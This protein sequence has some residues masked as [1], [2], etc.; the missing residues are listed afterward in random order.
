MKK[1]ALRLVRTSVG[2]VL[3]PGG[4]L[5]GLVLVWMSPWLLLALGILLVSDTLAGS[6]RSIYQ[7]AGALLRIAA[8]LGALIVSLDLTI[9]GTA[10]RLASERLMWPLGRA[11]YYLVRVVARG[12][13][14]ACGAG[15]S[16]VGMWWITSFLA[17]TV[18]IPDEGLLPASLHIRLFSAPL[19]AFC[20]V[21]AL[22]A[23]G[24]VSS[25]RYGHLVY[26]LGM[27]MTVAMLD[28]RVGGPGWVVSELA[29]ALARWL[30]GPIVRGPD[31]VTVAVAGQSPV[32]AVALVAEW[33]WGVGLALLAGV[34][35][36]DRADIT[37]RG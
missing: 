24:T 9:R 5:F 35:V 29:T 11:E 16:A 14:A 17:R 21:C 10:G 32:H 19:A 22:A 13:V 37:A 6:I 36:F 18:M 27:L 1:A 28:L 20:A 30:L 25:S 23:L 15:L 34:L 4:R 8:L 2:E 3:A 26:W 33:L 31:L 12:V 7:D